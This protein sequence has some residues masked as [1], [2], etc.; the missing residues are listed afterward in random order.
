MRIEANDGL[1]GWG[2]ATLEGH[3]E[4]VDGALEYF[5]RHIIGLDSN[6][7]ENIWQTAYRGGFYRGG[8]VLMVSASLCHYLTAHT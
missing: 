4:A 6:N 1:V 2:E 8:P 5:K 3:T 7:I